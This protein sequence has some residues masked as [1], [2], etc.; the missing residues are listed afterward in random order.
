MI[1]TIW[2]LAPYREEARTLSAELGI[3]SE[4]AQILV[5]R[6][7]CDAEAAGKFLFGNLDGLHDPY[8]MRDMKEAVDRIRQAIS[9]REKILIFGDYD[10]DGILSVVILSKALESL[11]AEVDYF[12]PERL[13]EGYGIKE[14]YIDIVLERKVGLVIS[15]DCGIKATQ[16]AKRAKEVGVDIIITDHHLPGDIL[17][18]AKAILNPVLDDSGYPDRS[19]AGIGVVFKLIQAL[20][21]REGKSSSLPH[22]M[23]LVSI[24]TIADVAE[25]KGENRLFVKFG[26]KG[27]EEVANTGLLSLM[28]FC[29]LSG[30]KVSARDVGY[31]I[32]P[33]IN[34]AG[35]MGMTDLAVKLFFTDSLPESLELVGHLDKLNSKRQ[36]TQEKIYE[37]A[38]RKIR[39]RNLD[40][41]YKFLILGC[42][43][44][45]RGV[46]GIV[47]SKLKDYFHRPVLIFV[48]EVGKA[49]GSGR[50]I[51]DFP[52]IACLDECKDLFLNYGGHSMAVGCVLA[53]ENLE[54]F[55]KAANA[56][57]D[58]RITDDHLKR[59]IYIDSKID[60][61][62][63]SSSF[64]ENFYLLSPFG[65]GNP[66]PIFLTEKAEVV[67]EPLKIQ[68]KHAKLLVRQKGRI[69]EALGWERGEWAQS[70]QKGD[71][72]DLAYSFQFSEYMGKE[73]L[74][75]S[76]E[77]IKT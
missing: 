65:V 68:G 35:R 33:R 11:G 18:Q 57:V 34:A 13:K 60:F 23:K 49:Y 56:Y 62:D 15:V 10:V 6:N 12:I 9:Q 16:F 40:R 66:K 24:G 58:S 71:K 39:K 43:E 1:E 53:H 30:K 73:K 41:R 51:N 54:L 44:W 38:L 55:K 19:L 76:L 36:K 37:Q 59:K 75:L 42:E 50:S 69:F 20:F 17:P 22:Y 63:I 7:L 3:P 46:I 61:S 27:L 8:L 31:R 25:L 52:L 45:H 74:S 26:L 72:I 21:E 28:E 29:G 48:Y 5:N 4:I 14:K 77:D 70:V 32:G 64:I 47:A 2:M 67:R